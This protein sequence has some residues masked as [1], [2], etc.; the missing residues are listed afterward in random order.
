MQRHASQLDAHWLEGENN[1]G[2]IVGSACGEKQCADTLIWYIVVK[3]ICDYG[4]LKFLS[5][6]KVPFVKVEC[7]FPPSLSVGSV[8]I[9]ASTS[10][11]PH[12]ERVLPER[13]QKSTSTKPFINWIQC[14]I[15][16]IE[17]RSTL[18]I[19]QCHGKLLS[20]Y[21]MQPCISHIW[22]WGGSF[23]FLSPFGFTASPFVSVF[24]FSQMHLGSLRQTCCRTLL[25]ERNCIHVRRHVPSRLSIVCLPAPPLTPF[26]L[27]FFFVPL[28][29][30]EVENEASAG[31]PSSGGGGTAT[32]AERRGWGRVRVD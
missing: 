23:F 18:D 24:D 22:M 21:Q 17:K 13:Y 25:L 30:A 1:N 2:E 29:S 27:G 16:V 28:D 3:K 26:L 12:L 7:F 32:A 10:N 11:C 14:C 9:T 4:C 15:T 19:F 31:S 20:F 8:P 6:E 5:G